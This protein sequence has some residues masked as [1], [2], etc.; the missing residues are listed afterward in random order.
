M[1]YVIPRGGSRVTLD[2]YDLNGRRVRR[3]VDGVLEAGM[4]R[5]AFD[6]RDDRGEKLSAGM[7]FARLSSGAEQRVTRFILLP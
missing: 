3:L 1:D 2:V 4:H 6:G 5:S 7:F